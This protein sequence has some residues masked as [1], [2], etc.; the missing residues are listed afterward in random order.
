MAHQERNRGETH[1][2]MKEIFNRVIIKRAHPRRN[3]SFLRIPAQLYAHGLQQLKL[4]ERQEEDNWEF[5]RETIAFLEYAYYKDGDHYR[6]V[7][8]CEQEALNHI[9]Y[10]FNEILLANRLALE[11]IT[12][13]A[14]AN[15][16]L[17]WIQS[18]RI[19]Q[20]SEDAA[21]RL[22]LHVAI[23]LHEAK[24][25]GTRHR[26]VMLVLTDN[27]DRFKKRALG[28]NAW[29]E[30]SPRIPDIQTN[31]KTSCTRNT[32]PLITSQIAS[33]R[34]QC[35]LHSHSGLE[36]NRENRVIA[37]QENVS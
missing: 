9:A 18:Y 21:L 33:A 34:A 13:E 12:L 11:S 23:S 17:T 28:I 14:I 26:D 16:F 29:L 24:I 15:E 36:I 30:P 35:N 25:I 27:E 20:I 4:I 32:I 37:V 6:L 8:E 2:L 5:V 31:G 1:S 3:R 22:A 7:D 10:F 19:Q